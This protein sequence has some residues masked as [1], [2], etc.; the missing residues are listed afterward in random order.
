MNCKRFLLLVLLSATLCACGGGGEAPATTPLAL[1]DTFRLNTSPSSSGVM[2]TLP[3]HVSGTSGG[4]SVSGNGT[5]TV[6]STDLTSGAF[7]GVPALQRSSTTSGTMTLSAQG[8]TETVLI[9]SKTTV[10]YYDTNY[11]PKGSSSSDEYEIIDNYY[12]FPTT[13]KV[14]D[15]AVVSTSNRYATSSKVMS[16]GISEQSYV[17]ES[18]T[19]STAQLKLI[20]K[21]IDVSGKVSIT[22][23]YSR[24][25]STGKFTL[26]Y[27]TFTDSSGLTLTLT[28]NAPISGGV[29]ISFSPS[30][31]M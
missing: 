17:L 24:I 28:F 16:L 1:T 7:E 2:L 13:I 5:M 30:S 8:Q 20:T 23:I 4:V 21:K 12:G 11:V 26:L 14:G 3:F 25:T 22:A 18:E 31:L 10:Y 19:A 9:P 6:A 29:P 27:G 15:S